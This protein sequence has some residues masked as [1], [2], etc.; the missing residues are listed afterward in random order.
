MSVLTRKILPPVFGIATVG[1]IIGGTIWF[2]NHQLSAPLANAVSNASTVNSSIAVLQN[3]TPSNDACCDSTN[4]Q[5]L[6]LF[7]KKNKFRFAENEELKTYFKDLNA[8]LQ[9]NP[10]VRLKIAALHSDT[11]GGE[12]AKNR[13]TFITDFLIRK[14]INVAQI[15]FED[16][17]TPLNATLADADNL[18]NQ[19]IEIRLL[20]P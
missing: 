5:A 6:N 4:F 8:Y 16:K 20:T 15:I 10:T 1:W 3:T 17:K 7:F 9:R 14:K 18:K 11:E 2:D 13:L 12:I 19:R